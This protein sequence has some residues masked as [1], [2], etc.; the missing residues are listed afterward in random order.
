MQ[1]VLFNEKEFTQKYNELKSSRKMAEYF[2]C[3]KNTILNYAKRI[4]YNN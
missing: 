2:K 3:S 1:K 4:N